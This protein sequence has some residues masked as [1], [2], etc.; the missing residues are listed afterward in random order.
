MAQ[1]HWVGGTD[2]W[3][4]TAGSKWALTA[5]G[6]GGQAVPTSSDDVFFDASSGSGTITLSGSRSA[7]SLNCTG[8]TGTFAMGNSA[9]TLNVSGDV[10]FVPGMV[11]SHTD[12]QLNIIA[13]ASITSGGLTLPIVTLNGAAATFTLQDD[14]IT[15]QGLVVTDGTFVANNFDVTTL[16][17]AI[18]RS[19]GKTT[20][21]NMGSGLWT[22]TGTVGSGG[23][24]VF[25]I[26]GA[27]PPTITEGTSTIK[28]IDTSNT[29][30][31]VT[32]NDDTFYDIWFSRASSTGK[33]T[34]TTRFQ[35]NNYI[36][37]GTGTHTIQWKNSNT[38]TFAAQSSTSG[39]HVS[40]N[41]G[42]LIT[43]NK[44]SGGSAATISVPGGIVGCDYLSITNVHASGGAT[45]YAGGNSTDGGNTTGWIFTAIPAGRFWVGGTDAWDSDAGDKWALS[46]GGDGGAPVPTALDDVTFDAASGAVTVTKT[47][48][49]ACKDL[50]FTGF[51]GTLAGTGSIAIAG[52]VVTLGSGMTWSSTGVDVLSGT[53]VSLTSNGKTIAGGFTYDSSGGVLTIEDALSVTGAVTLEEG[54]FDANDKTITVGSFHSNNSNVRELIMGSGLW[55]LTSIATVWEL[56]NSNITFT[57]DTANIKLTNNS[58]SAKIFTGGSLTYNDVWIANAGAGTITING[59]N[60]YDDLKIDNG[61]TVEFEDGSNQ[62]AT[63]FTLAAG[64]QRIIRGTGTGN[65]T[66]TVASGTVSSFNS[67]ISYSQAV[68]GAT[69]EAFGTNGNLNGGNNSGWIFSFAPLA[70]VITNPVTD[71]AKTTATAHGEVVD[72]GGETITERGFVWSI[73]PSPTTADDKVIVAGTIGVYSGALTALTPG[74]LYYVRAYAMTIA[75]TGYGDNVMFTTQSDQARVGTLDTGFLDYDRPIYF[76]FIDRWRS[77]TDLYAKVESI[78]GFNVYTENAGGA[79]VYFQDQKSPPNVW[80]DPLGTIDQNSNSLFP[81]AQTMDYNAGRIRIAGYSSG[82]PIVIHSIEILSVQDKGFDQN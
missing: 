66:I 33:I 25:F 62:T 82:D 19:L 18:G 45:F 71:I 69:F 34:H 52:D 1:R 24:A 21:L 39:F 73:N 79:R 40:G 35:C 58:A 78:S 46:S 27:S 3:N 26:D 15:D 6:A 32:W 4:G 51:T 20:A 55:T 10:L 57:K 48:S 23:V 16:S 38:Y 72:D 50:V 63:T 80:G 68:G 5:G 47:G 7:K 59:S 22:I 65:W 30:I 77:Y 43:M 67:T 2:T 81:N 14:L 74:T 41:A 31:V 12:S 76:D 70:T 17:F 64:A 37:D 9:N 11:L 44:D 49:L 13:T 54:T 61:L 53:A 56:S 60:T 29:D 28:F 36:D 42:H 75:G 8:F